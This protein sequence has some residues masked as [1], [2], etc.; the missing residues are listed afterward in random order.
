VIA[1]GN[2][3]KGVEKKDHHV[4]VPKGLIEG[5]E[6]FESGGRRYRIATVVIDRGMP[7]GYWAVLQ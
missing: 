1:A 3:R 5:G 7:T 4:P 6:T 2:S